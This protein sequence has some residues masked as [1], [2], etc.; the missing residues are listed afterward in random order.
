LQ[1]DARAFL[2]LLAKHRRV[3]L[4]CPITLVYGEAD[5]ALRSAKARRR[6]ARLFGREIREI[7]IVGARHDV[8]HTH[9]D[10]VARALL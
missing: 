2:R 1:A 5:P 9:A 4:S 6:W 3:E 8:I 10:E 7:A